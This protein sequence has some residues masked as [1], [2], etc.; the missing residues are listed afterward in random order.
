MKLLIAVLSLVAGIAHAGDRIAQQP[1]G[2]IRLTDAACTNKAVVAQILPQFVKDFKAG[3]GVITD[4]ELA[5]VL[6]VDTF[7]FC[8]TLD[9][10]AILI[11]D[12]FGDV[13]SFQ[14]AQFEAAAG[15]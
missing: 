6:G 12:Q 15:V 1:F 14:P 5:K 9:K 11:V 4:K 7:D 8:W 10:G 3:K 2:S 13:V